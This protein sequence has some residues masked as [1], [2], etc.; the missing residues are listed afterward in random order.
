MINT[1]THPLVRPRAGAVVGRGKPDC[2]VVSVHPPGGGGTGVRVLPEER[3][4]VPP[5]E[6]LRLLPVMNDNGGKESSIQPT[7]AR[8]VRK[9]RSAQQ[10][11][12]F[13][14]FMR[15]YLLRTHVCTWP[16][17]LEG[18]VLAFCRRRRLRTNRHVSKLS[19][20]E[21]QRM[22]SQGRRT[23]H[24]LPSSCMQPVASQ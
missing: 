14:S 11:Q 16:S 15:R 8:R 1:S 7:T 21:R 19:L 10:L 12:Q 22:V 17:V 20:P 13:Q 3:P 24:S 5:R 2:D 18:K 9:E 23:L 4:P 6:P